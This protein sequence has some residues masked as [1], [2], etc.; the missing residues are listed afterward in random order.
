MRRVGIDLPHNVADSTACTLLEV[1]SRDQRQ[2]QLRGPCPTLKKGPHGSTRASQV[3]FVLP[4]K[5][6]SCQD[7]TLDD[8]VF[9]RASCA[10]LR[11]GTL[12]HCYTQYSFFLPAHCRYTAQ[13]TSPLQRNS[14][15]P[16]PLPLS[17]F[18][19]QLSSV[20]QPGELATLL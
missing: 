18:A 19:C 7:I 17:A 1:P 12:C 5:P 11:S 3:P 8:P 6:A 9:F 15:S 4:C 16:F 20:R 13:R 14:T 10:F 2:H